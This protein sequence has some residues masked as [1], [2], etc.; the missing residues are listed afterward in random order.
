M[1]H[2]DL[3]IH[4][5]KTCDDIGQSKVAKAI[6][7]SPTTVSQIYNGKYGAD[8][9]AP[10]ELFREK[11]GGIT[12]TC[13]VLGEISLDKCAFHRRREFAASNPVRVALFRSCP[14]CT[15]WREGGGKQL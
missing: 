15:A 12:V 10:L 1:S 14:T 11:F 4:F 6:G 13:P 5:R 8:D 7:A 2:D 9:S 3:L